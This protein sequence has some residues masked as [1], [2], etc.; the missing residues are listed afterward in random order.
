MKQNLLKGIIRVYAGMAVKRFMLAI[1]VFLLLQGCKGE[2]QVLL[3]A[4]RR[5]R[6]ELFT[7]QDFSKETN[8]ITFESSIS[9]GRTVLWDSVFNAIPLKDIPTEMNK[10]VFEKVVL[11]SSPELKVGFK[12]T[13]ENVG[14]SWYYEKALLGEQIKTVTFDFR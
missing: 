14:I 7:S 8:S 5:I 11:N 3:P 6:F 12:Y 9:D 4:S 2:D 1:A 13:I 10:I